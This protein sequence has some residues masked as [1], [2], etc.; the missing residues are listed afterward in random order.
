M[1]HKI[2]RPQHPRP[3]RSDGDANTLT[4]RFFFWRIYSAPDVPKLQSDVTK[5]QTIRVHPVLDDH[6]LAGMLA[7]RTDVVRLQTWHL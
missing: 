2:R 1:S 5:T 7:C 3:W 4:V 6:F